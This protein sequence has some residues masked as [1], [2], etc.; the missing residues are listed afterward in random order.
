[1]DNSKVGQNDDPTLV[2][3]LEA[4][5]DL[6]TQA[7]ALASQMEALQEK[8]RS[9]KGVIQLFSP[10]STSTT[11]TETKSGAGSKNN[12][13]HRS[14]KG[15]HNLSQEAAKASLSSCSSTGQS[16]LNLF[17]EITGDMTEDEIAQLPKDGAEQ[18]DHYIYGTPKR[19][20]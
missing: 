1:M 19:Q 16:L 2:K 8:R 10:T 4:D 14:K 7:A 12:K 9:L 5:S 18:H 6:A 15:Q 3:L 17:T 11:E 13:W 20:S